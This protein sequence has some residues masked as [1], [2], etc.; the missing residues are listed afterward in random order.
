MPFVQGVLG[1]LSRIFLYYII[2]TNRCL[3]NLHLPLQVKLELIRQA[4]SL[5]Q[6]RDI[7]EGA[8]SEVGS[9]SSVT[10]WKTKEH[11]PRKKKTKPSNVGPIRANQPLPQEIPSQQMRFLGPSALSTCLIGWNG[12]VCF[13]M[14]FGYWMTEAGAQWPKL[15]CF[16]FFFFNE[17]QKLFRTL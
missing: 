16:F 17:L 15:F 8:A 14:W 6:V 12:D 5:E 3:I 9:P 4:E 13:G 7:L 1:T 11:I 10:S 2:A